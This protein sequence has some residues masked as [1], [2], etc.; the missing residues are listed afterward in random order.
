MPLNSYVRLD[1]FFL[2]FFPFVSFLCNQNWK[3]RL[4]GDIAY[5]FIEVSFGL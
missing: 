1:F 4:F 5:A 2:S 3:V